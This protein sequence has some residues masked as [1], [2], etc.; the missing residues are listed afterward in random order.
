M[1]ET[2]AN[3]WSEHRHLLAPNEIYS[4]ERYLDVTDI[5]SQTINNNARYDIHKL[6]PIKHLILGDAK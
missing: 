3:W 5:A 1:G 6:E 4:F 2:T